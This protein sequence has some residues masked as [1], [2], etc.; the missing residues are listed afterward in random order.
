MNTLAFEFLLRQVMVEAYVS[1]IINEVFV[2]AVKAF[3]V[4]SML[5]HLLLEI[6]VLL[7]GID[8]HT[9]ETLT[10]RP[11]RA[12]PRCFGHFPRLCWFIR[13]RR[14]LVLTGVVTPYAV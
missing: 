12:F 11:M 3:R 9:V 2:N 4:W 13:V 7:L 10:A 14:L 6:L 1:Y 5:A 8:S